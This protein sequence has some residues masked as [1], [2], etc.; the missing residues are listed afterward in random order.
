MFI[1]FTKEFQYNQFAASDNER[2]AEE[3]LVNTVQAWFE[4]NHG[5]FENRTPC[6]ADVD[7]DTDSW[8]L[9]AT[10]PMGR[11]YTAYAIIEVNERGVSQF[12]NHDGQPGDR[13]CEQKSGEWCH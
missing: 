5:D 2:E 8:E 4:Q 1:A 12:G 10:T 3:L 9:T 6:H 11:F 13:G 7:I